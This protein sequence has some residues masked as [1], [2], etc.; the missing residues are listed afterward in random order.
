MS[1]LSPGIN[2]F[3][4]ADTSLGAALTNPTELAKAKGVISRSYPV[5]FNG[6][7]YPDAEVAYQISKQYARDRDSLMVEIL[8]AKFRQ[9]PDLAQEVAA[10]GGA[11]WLATCDHLT[12][13]RSDS[14]QAWEG[15]GLDSRYIRN[16][17]QAFTMLDNSV[18]T[19]LGQTSL[20]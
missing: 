9:H 19:Q 1:N 13:A 15:R 18:D 5:R 11:A 6:N 2:I 12:N 4:G 7:R 3:S 16:L 20:F 10:R 17:V 14:A 8:V